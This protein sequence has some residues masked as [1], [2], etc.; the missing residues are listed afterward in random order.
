MESLPKKT[1]SGI[2]VK[3]VY[4]SEDLPKE[5]DGNQLPGSFP[6]TRGVQ[7]D[8][9][10]GKLWTMRQYAGFSTA[11]ESNQ[12]Y[13]FLLAQGVMG[14]SVAFDL[15]TQIGYDADHDLADGEVGKVG[16]SICSL[17]D[18]E[19]LFKDIPLDKISTSMTINATGFILL[20]FYVALAK[21]RGV[22]LSALSGT[23]QNDILKEYA[24]RGT[25]IY[26]PKPSMRIITDIFEWCS[27]H[28]PK[29]NSISISGYHIREA[30][31]TAVQE[32]AFTLSNG[33]AYV[34]AAQAKGLDI[35]VFGKRLSFFFNAH[36]NLFEEV[37]KFRAAR[38][39]WAKIMK[40]LGATDE[41]ALMLRFHTQTGGATL[42][43]QQPH[44]NISRVTVQTIA[45]VL[46]GTQSLHTNGFDEALGLPTQEAA[47]IALRTQQIVAFES[48][49]ADTADPLAGSYFVE[50]LTKEI[51]DKSWELMQQIDQ[52]GGSV[53]AIETG[54]MQNKIAESA[55]AYQ[56]AI[57]SNE[58]IIVG[59]NQF[60]ND[61]EIDIPILKI[62]ESIRQEQIKNLQT[63]K[64]NR[65]HQ[66]V[67]DCLLA[68]K[69]AAK[70]GTNL[71][72]PV[73]EAVEAF[74]T[75]GEISDAL[76]TVFGEYQ[77]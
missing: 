25:Y 30:G 41:K 71:M 18:M 44:N 5:I 42:T 75:L 45:A 49:I 35:N 38:T 56:K 12:R 24:A 59:V 65:D 15:P 19:I 40:D 7:S 14:L 66:K 10:R 28:L 22:A 26:P 27:E 39:M 55:Y 32:L 70:E 37:A 20:A 17:K 72:P 8:M 6:Y 64:N 74:C 60:R 1:D 52:M 69:T 51:E 33:K 36:N 43:A 13:H 29:W 57:E 67:A 77:S 34:Q 9:Y 47:S 73:I 61:S 68:I 31:S 21:Q 16:V 46:G 4:T 3:K 50:N 23:I 76:R 54:F 11:E 2:E 58:K 63:L 62:N 53:A 48:G